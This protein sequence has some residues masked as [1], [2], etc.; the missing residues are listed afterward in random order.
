MQDEFQGWQSGQKDCTLYAL[1]IYYEE[2]NELQSMSLC[3]IS[4]V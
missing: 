1:I 3:I 4:G 2:N